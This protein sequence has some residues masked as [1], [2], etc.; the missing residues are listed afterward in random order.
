MLQ[1]HE[2]FA[3]AL[4]KHKPRYSLHGHQLQRRECNLHR[5]VPPAPQLLRSSP[6][7]LH[8]QKCR[9]AQRRCAL[10]AGARTRR[11]RCCGRKHHACSDRERQSG[12]LTGTHRRQ[13]PV[14][15]LLHSQALGLMVPS[16]MSLPST[17]LIIF[18]SF[19]SVPLTCSNTCPCLQVNLV[20]SDHLAASRGLAAIHGILGHCKRSGAFALLKRICRDTVR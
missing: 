10:H 1:W 6:C 16:C 2:I 9:P 20:F 3:L 18:F 8:R 13:P 12:G 17:N 7:V 19:S 14:I 11:C 15:Q 4:S 5:Q